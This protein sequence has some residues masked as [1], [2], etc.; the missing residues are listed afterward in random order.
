MREIVVKTNGNDLNKIIS[1][2]SSLNIKSHSWIFV[3]YNI[4]YKKMLVF[5]KRKV[6]LLKGEKNQMIKVI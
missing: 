6:T 3:Q 1:T 4:L 2:L 5:I